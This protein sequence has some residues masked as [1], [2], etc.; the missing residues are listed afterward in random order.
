VDDDASKGLAERDLRQAV[1]DPLPPARPQP[2][3]VTGLAFRM[4]GIAAF[5][6]AIAGVVL[7]GLPATPFLLVAAWAFARGSPAW[8][9]RI[10]RHPRL[11]PLLRNWREGQVV[12]RRAKVFAVLSMIASMLMLW[13]TAASVIM[14]AAVGSMMLAGAAYLLSRPE[15]PRS[16]TTPDRADKVDRRAHEL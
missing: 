1:T 7:P 8:A 10:E 3:R 9:A 15:R 16:V 14:L 6:L 2:G 5:G 11:G 12:P 4:L 13:A